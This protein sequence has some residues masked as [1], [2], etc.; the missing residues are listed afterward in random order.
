MEHEYPRRLQ[1]VTCAAGEVDSTTSLFRPSGNGLLASL[2]PDVSRLSYVNAEK[3]TEL[4]V[5]VRSLDSLWSEHFGWENPVSVRFLKIDVEG[6]ECA[7]IRGA[8]KLI[9]RYAP[10]YISV[11]TNAHHVFT[12]CSIFQISQQLPGYQL[13]QLMPFSNGVVRRD[14]AGSVSNVHRFANFVFVADHVQLPFE[15]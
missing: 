12:E 8:S 7:V 9:S 1:I 10:D 14:P 6:H 11:E 15:A 13:I 5:A 2:H 4:P 3:V